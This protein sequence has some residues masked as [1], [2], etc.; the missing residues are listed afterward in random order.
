MADRLLLLEQQRRQEEARRQAGVEQTD[1]Q[2]DRRTDKTRNAAR[3]QAGLEESERLEQEKQRLMEQARENERIY[4]EELQRL[5]TYQLFWLLE[6]YRL[7]FSKVT[8]LNCSSCFVRFCITTV[9]RRLYLYYR[10]I[11]KFTFYSAYYIYSMY[12]CAV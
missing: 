10:K 11:I 6:R 8:P 5:I 9:F 12:D 2:T 3:R 7:S 4:H 1:G